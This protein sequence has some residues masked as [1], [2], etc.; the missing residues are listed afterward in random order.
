MAQHFSA[1]SNQYQ[2]VDITKLPCYLPSL[3]PPQVDIWTVYQKI[4]TQKKTKST[5]PIDLPERLKKEFSVELAVPLT[6][7]FNAC[8]NQSIYPKMWKHEWVTPV[9]KVTLPKS[10]SD[11]RKI[12]CT[13][14]YSKI[15]EGYLKEWIMRDIWEKLDPSQFCG[16]KGT[17]TEHLVVKLVDRLQMLLDRNPDKSAIIA[18]GVDWFNAFDRVDP[19]IAIEKFINLGI[20]PSLIPLLIDY[21]TDR[22]MSVKF[23]SDVS[24][25]Y[26]LIGGGPQ[27]TVLGQTQ[28]T[29]ASNDV[30]R[31]VDD[32][33]RYKYC[34]D[35]TV[36]EL[37]CLSVILTDYDILKH[38]PSDIGI[39]QTFL[40][41]DSYSMQK[42]LDHITEWTDQNKMQLNPSKSNF[43]IFSTRLQL[44]NAT[45]ERK[46]VF[47]LC[48]VYFTE[49]LSWAE[50]T[51]QICLFKTPDA[52]QT[53]ICWLEN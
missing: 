46:S 21:I 16:Q 8:L 2:P 12:A 14:D 9:P 31:D 11:L 28:Y 52:V 50:N 29:I 23:N 4:K 36:I 6:D 7:I 3:P 39:D 45:I 34:D 44:N 15:F 19:T 37:V 42:S 32:D 43:T 10:I 40:P 35:L 22:K 13:S 1:V 33:D 18:V 30:A 41:A 5:L 51:N 26:K 25:I 38:I 49:N 17:G 47:K 53:K 24:S 48:G 20:R 27:G